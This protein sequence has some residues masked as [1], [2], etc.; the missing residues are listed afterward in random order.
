MKS[1]YSGIAGLA[2]MAGSAFAAAA[3]TP[4]SFDFTGLGSQSNSSS[5]HVTSAAGDVVAT[6]TAPGENVGAYSL[7]GVGVKTGF[8]NLS[9]IQDGETL[10]VSFS[11]DVNI[12]RISMR[13]WE[14]PDRVL[15]GVNTDQGSY[16]F[17]LDNDSCGLCSGEDFEHLGLEDVNYITITGDS[18][19]TVTFLS[20]LGVT[21]VPLPAAA[22]LFGSA[23]LGLVAVARRRTAA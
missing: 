21:V 13:Q 6:V 9:G 11:E 19:A 15:V 2:L 23:L 20:G 14:G 17:A 16:S 12:D 22:Y 3:N 1:I 10:K 4:T 5:I 7:D 8:F 18:F